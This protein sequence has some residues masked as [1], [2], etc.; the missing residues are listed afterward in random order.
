MSHSRT[1]AETNKLEECSTPE[2]QTI[3]DRRDLSQISAQYL[4]QN[5]INRMHPNKNLVSLVVIST[6]LTYRTLFIP[7]FLI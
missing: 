3:C 2:N 7:I 5:T 1:F 4:L 6:Q